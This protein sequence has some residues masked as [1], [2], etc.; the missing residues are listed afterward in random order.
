MS[1]PEQ[2]RIVVMIPA[3][4]NS[5]R[6]PGKPLA[7]ILGLPMIEHV[8]RR[9]SLCR[10]IADVFVATCDVEIRRV[11]ESYGGKVIMTAPTHERCTDRIEEAAT[12]LSCDV[13][14]NVQGDEPTI[15]PEVVETVAAPL[16]ADRTLQ[17]T[18]LVYPIR[19]LKELQNVNVVKTVLSKNSLILYFSRSSIPVPNASETVTFYKQSGIMGFQKTFLHLYSRLEPTPLEVAES[20]DM[21]RILE[22]DYKIMGIVTSQ[23]SFGVD[24]PADVAKIE[25]LILSDD[26]QRKVYNHI[27]QE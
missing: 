20:V 24:V 3:R 9:V 10:K 12:A 4:M 17:S 21:L 7:K 23:E 2:R 6:F 1:G 11:V 13:V 19:D 14:I 8:R 22:H 16:L 15:L 27:K 5:S 25:K 18:C 26:V